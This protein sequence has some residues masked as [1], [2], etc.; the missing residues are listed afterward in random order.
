MSILIYYIFS[1]W[2]E[3]TIWNWNYFYLQ[4]FDTFQNSTSLFLVL[5]LHLKN[6]TSGATERQ[7]YISSIQHLCFKPSRAP[8]FSSCQ[9]LLLN[10][11]SDLIMV[12]RNM[13]SV[14][15]KIEH[16][17]FKKT[18]SIINNSHHLPHH[19]KNIFFSP[20]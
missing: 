19:K 1:V 14:F 5:I 11:S 3:H 17:K 4:I 6:I 9:I 15:A 10:F 8:E 16:I 12:I 13:F 7:I 2:I 18:V 20:S